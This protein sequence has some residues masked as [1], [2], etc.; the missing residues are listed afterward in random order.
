M[1]IQLPREQEQFLKELVRSG[2]HDSPDVAISD[3]LWLLKNH[4]DL[5][6]AQTEDL[7]RL[8]AVGIEQSERGE[9]LDGQEVFRRLKE[10]R[11]AHPRTGAP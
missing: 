4:Y 7:R 6:R 10:K 1:N 3:A 5:H 8:I 11:E 9:C 2:A